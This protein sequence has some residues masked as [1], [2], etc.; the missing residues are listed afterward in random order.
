MSTRYSRALAST[1]TIL[2]LH[3]AAI[4]AQGPVVSL[5]RGAAL[6]QQFP[7]VRFSTL[8]SFDLPAAEGFSHSASVPR[9]GAAAEA[10]VL[11]D[12][13]VALHGRPASIRGFMLPIDVNASGVASFILT[14][15]ID[16]CH[17]GMIGLPHEWVLVEMA[18]SKRVPYLKYQPVTVFGRLSVEPQYRGTRLSGLYQLR[19]EFITADGL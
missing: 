12:A 15:S 9:A 14:A 1:M 7:F 13:V 10:L 18:G 3:C 17:W 4:A 8:A 6:K 16:S 5:E 11:P 19:A 2:L